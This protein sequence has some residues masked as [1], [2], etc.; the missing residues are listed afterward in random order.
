[1]QIAAKTRGCILL[2]VI[3]I[4]AHTCI[5]A[6]RVGSVVKSCANYVVVDGFE[7][8]EHLA[9]NASTHVETLNAVFGAADWLVVV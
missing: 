2:K 6:I 4:A 7:D 9:L 8:K 3:P 5:S 1:M